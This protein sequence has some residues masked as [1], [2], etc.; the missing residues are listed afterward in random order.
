MD[1][2]L[3]EERGREKD[4]ERDRERERE[5]RFLEIKMLLPE[6]TAVVFTLQSSPTS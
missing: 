5:R 1:I 4:R 6:N 3:Y 2:I